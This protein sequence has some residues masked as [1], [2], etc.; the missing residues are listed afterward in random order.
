MKAIVFDFDGTLTKKSHEIWEKIWKELDAEDVDY[1]LY[2][3]YKNKEIDYIEWCK[4]IET[5]YIKRGFNEKMLFHISNGIE[6]MDNL[7]ETL[8]IL[9]NS[10]YSLYIV[11][12]GIDKVIYNK[13]G[14]LVDYFD[15]ITCC[16][17]NFDSIGNLVSIV[18]TKYEDEGKKLFIEEYCEKFHVN[19]NDIFFVGNGNNDEY[20]YLSGCNTICLNP[21]KNTSHKDNKIWN[22][23][24]MN[25]TNMKDILSFIK[26]NN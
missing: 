11:S 24:L 15:G 5:E 2:L 3:K 21:G 8:K 20:V 1:K 19:P 10:G 12:G 7:E 6:L 18:P 4:E 17:F 13:L 16:R 14:S 22:K 25:T 9:K 26:H 23:V